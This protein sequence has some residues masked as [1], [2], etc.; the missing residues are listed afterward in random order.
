MV[1]AWVLVGVVLLLVEMHNLAFF[2]VFAAIGAF[3][4]AGVAGVAPDAIALQGAVAAGLGLA[5]MVAVRPWVS[6]AIDARRTGHVIRGVHGG[7]V[8]S[9]GVTLDRVGDVHHQGHVRLTG[10]RW[11]AVT[12]GGEPIAAGVP[13]VVTAVR[14]TTLVV[15]PIEAAPGEPHEIGPQAPDEAPDGAEG[16]KQ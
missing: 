2:A 10:E 11:L 4:A 3:A 9:E 7:L 15:W 12:G 1:V 14:G 16:R 13:V 8:G 6:R 5:G